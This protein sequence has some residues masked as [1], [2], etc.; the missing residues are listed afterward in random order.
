MQAATEQQLQELAPLAAEL[1]LS[2]VLA[3]VAS[4]LEQGNPAMRWLRRHQRGESVAAIL[5][6]A[7]A[8]LAER[9]AQLTAWLATDASH[10]LGG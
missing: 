7:T 5:T 6:A 3:P 8:E 10:A 4:L 2:Q 1:G 9:E